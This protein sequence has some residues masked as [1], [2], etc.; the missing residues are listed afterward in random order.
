MTSLSQR[1]TVL[2]MIDEAV[3]TGARVARACRTLG[4]SLR[5]V[6][7][8]RRTPCRGDQR[9]HRVQRPANGF[10][11]LERQRIL[12]V[13]NSEEYGHLP[14]SPIVPRLADQGQYL[15]SES[16]MYRLLRSAGQLTHR[17]R[18]RPPNP[19]PKPRGVTARAPNELYS[20]DITDMPTVI[21]GRFYYLYLFL[22]LFSRKI[23]G[24]QVYDTEDGRHASDIV[25][26]I[27]LHEGIEPGQLVLHSD[28][29]GPTRGAIMLATL[30]ELGV[31][32]S[33]SRPAVS[34]DNP[35]S[36]ALFRTLKYRPQY[37]R[38]PFASLQQA[39]TWVGRFVRW[40]NT[41]HRHGAIRFVTPEQ[42]H[43]GLDAAL[44]AQ[45]RAVYEAA[46]RRAPHR[47]SGPLR[48]WSRVDVV[49]LNPDKDSA[50]SSVIEEPIRRAA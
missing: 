29:G 47:W 8:W 24:W 14:P 35:Y 40:Y 25:R 41:E 16:T 21:K 32:P 17:G 43:S 19:Q 10:S 33:F 37:P 48:N 50:G 4:L 18:Q 45:R 31:S 2:S 23:V 36:E 38:K 44:L 22:D 6:Q 1:Q 49:H 3:A 34:D 39:R 9:P 46:H 7:R 28:N 5:T 42:R 27:C 26:D 12:S 13:L 15:A 11:D 20:W 30:R